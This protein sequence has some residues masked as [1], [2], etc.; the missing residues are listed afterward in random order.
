MRTRMQADANVYTGDETPEREAEIA[1]EHAIPWALRGPS[2]PDVEFFK[3]QKKRKDGRFSTGGGF[4][5]RVKEVW[6]A[7][8]C[9]FKFSYKNT[10]AGQPLHVCAYSVAMYGVCSRVFSCVRTQLF[11]CAYSVVC[12]R[13]AMVTA[14][15]SC[16]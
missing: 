11:V 14:T 15:H 16:L 5:L 6:L 13:V 10:R 3:G 9:M 2:D 7:S 1:A 8:G 12:K 4:T